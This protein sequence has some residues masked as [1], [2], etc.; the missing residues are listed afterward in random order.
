MAKK[1]LIEHLALVK[2]S[3]FSQFSV[4]LVRNEGRRKK[5]RKEENEV[6][7][8]ETDRESERERERERKTEKKALPSLEFFSH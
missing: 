7:E 2:C 4:T 8:R 3:F 1:L 5:E 6:K